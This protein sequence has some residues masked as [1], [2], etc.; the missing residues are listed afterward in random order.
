[1]RARARSPELLKSGGSTLVV[2]AVASI[3]GLAVVT[4]PKLTIALSLALIGASTLLLAQARIY[5][6]L[7]LVG[8]VAVPLLLLESRTRGFSLTATP[9]SGQA[10]LLSLIALALIARTLAARSQILIPRLAT[11]A[12][13][14]YIFGLVSS[15]GVAYHV[16]NDYPAILSDLSRQAAYP[17]AFVVGVI[18]SQAAEQDRQRLQIYT[19]LALGGIAASVLSM[20]YWS[21]VTDY[22]PLDLPVLSTM[23]D[24]ALKSSLYQTRSIFPFIDDS[25][26]LGAIVFAC[27]A[28][29]AA[30]PLLIHGQ[31]KH[32]RL[33]LAL[34]AGVAA[35]ILT[36][37]SR[38][39]LIALAV[40]PL[41]LILLALPRVRRTRLI[42][43]L[44][45]AGT[46]A[47]YGYQFFPQERTISANTDAFLARE[48]VWRQ[49]LDKFEERPLLGQGYRY[50]AE[51]NFLEAI[52]SRNRPA[53]GLGSSGTRGSS[54]HS[55]YFGAVVDGGIVGGGILVFLLFVVVRVGKRLTQST[56]L[57]RAEG[58][59]ALSV[60][61]VFLVS[62]T[63]SSLLASAAAVIFFWLFFGIAAGRDAMLAAPASKAPRSLGRRRAGELH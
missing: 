30:P 51:N 52:R 56:G 32:Q 34:I 20:L 43:A 21:H 62:M 35:A 28:A 47:V 48:E 38:S 39:G 12:V 16:G 2:T 29:F 36:T 49:A 54:V 6:I 8:M 11:W 1:M 19:G 14:A 13:G 5:P 59:G 61:C 60:T 31:A 24:H 37:Q 42:G 17:L 7:I 41:P 3:L 33:A 22:L 45:I 53:I 18:A 4:V 55:D 58:I 25:P 26:N 50:S 44:A 9:V 23:F 15:L 63:T 10:R 27:F 40:A 57:A 46:I